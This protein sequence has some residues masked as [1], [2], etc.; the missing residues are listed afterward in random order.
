MPNNS[1]Q[2][3]H[4]RVLRSW[5]FSA[6]ARLFFLCY[7]PPGNQLLSFVF[8]N[9]VD[10]HPRGF[11][12]AASILFVLFLSV[13]VGCFFFWSPLDPRRTLILV[14]FLLHRYLLFI[15]SAFFLR[16]VSDVFATPPTSSEVYCSSL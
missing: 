10:R 11:G 9:L 15:A 7:R 5:P 2:G 8:G 4:V 16:L 6:G 12:W 14:S 3:A 13:S 1:P